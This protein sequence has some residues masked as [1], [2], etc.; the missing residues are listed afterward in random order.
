MFLG[1]CVDIHVP[2]NNN[3]HTSPRNFCQILPT[4]SFP[5]NKIYICNF[6]FISFNMMAPASLSLPSLA[7]ELSS[8]LQLCSRRLLT[9]DRE[10]RNFSIYMNSYIWR[11]FYVELESERTLLWRLF[12][13]HNAYL[14]PKIWSLLKIFVLF[15]QTW[16]DLT[17]IFLTRFKPLTIKFSR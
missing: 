9:K 16:C 10:A 12:W 7:E 5:R 13:T 1:A 2:R 6:T 3:T 8:C 15:L 11:F 17:K 14:P 4:F